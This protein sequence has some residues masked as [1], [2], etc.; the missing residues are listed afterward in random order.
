MNYQWYP[1]HMTKAK[2]MMQENIKLID[3]IIELVD[4]RIPMSS[5]NPDID[6]LAKGKARIILLNKSDLEA[7]V[8]EEELKDL[9]AGKDICLVRTSTKEN[10]GMEEFEEM[11]KDMFFRGQIK[12]NDEVVITNMRHKEALVEAEKSLQMVMDSLDMHMPEDFY[13]IDLMSAY[14]SLGY[15]IGEE[16]DEDLVNEIFTKFCMG[17]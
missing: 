4:A 10:S 6:E 3:L 7:K 17:K 12:A 9:F 14:A 8:F 15:I 16:V 2:R 13:S 11:I 5:R 1:G